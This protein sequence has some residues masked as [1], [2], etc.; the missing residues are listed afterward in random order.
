MKI[1][2]DQ[3]GLTLT[4]MS[5]SSSACDTLSAITWNDSLS[6]KSHSHIILSQ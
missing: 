3:E 6:L 4:L 5:S 1:D 2:D